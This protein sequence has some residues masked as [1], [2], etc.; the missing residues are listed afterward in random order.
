MALLCELG[1]LCERLRP[2]AAATAA[3]FATPLRV[4]PRCERDPLVIRGDGGMG[5]WGAPRLPCRV[6]PVTASG[7]SSPSL[8]SRTTAS[9]PV[10]S[11]ETTESVLPPSTSAG[12]VHLGSR[13]P[14]SG[15]AML[16]TDGGMGSTPPPHLPISLS[17]YL[18]P[19]ASRSALE[20][21]LS[22]AKTG[23]P[24]TWRRWRPYDGRRIPGRRRR[25]C[26]GG[27]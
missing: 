23:R 9:V 7:I 10:A 5:G 27:S 3:D 4:V 14:D 11:S 12:L 19:P 24:R 17:P 2:A 13:I 22:P 18:F 26:P 16:R 8:S 25:P 15:T 20:G 1:G 21:N 6:V